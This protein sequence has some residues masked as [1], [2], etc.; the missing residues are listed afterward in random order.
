MHEGH[1]FDNFLLI[2]EEIIG[3]GG[4]IQNR[5]ELIPVHSIEHPARAHPGPS[6]NHPG[7]V[8]NRERIGQGA[9]GSAEAQI[10]G[11]GVAGQ[12][13]LECDKHV[14]HRGR[15]VPAAQAAH[16]HIH[17]HP[18]FIFNPDHRFNHCRG[19]LSRGKSEQRLRAVMHRIAVR[20][21]HCRQRVGNHGVRLHIGSRG[22][23]AVQHP[24]ILSG[25]GARCI[26]RRFKAGL[27]NHLRSWAQ[28][29]PR[30]VRFRNAR[31]VGDKQTVDPRI[32]FGHMGQRQRGGVLSR[33]RNARRVG[34]MIAAIPL[35]GGRGR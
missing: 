21:A 8:I 34:Q 31:R 27:Q 32:S 25:D 16:P 33:H 13:S 14:P 23:R 4:V 22:P 2:E 29:Q 26:G 9:V 20:D 12:G 15:R 24:G 6:R 1:P 17:D 28:G 18:A 35:I 5:R 19:R 10:G 7:A 3:F 11:P 30:P